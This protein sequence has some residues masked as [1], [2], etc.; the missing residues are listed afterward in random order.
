MALTQNYSKKVDFIPIESD[1][2]I[3]KL[4]N[5]SLTEEVIIKNAYTKITK[6]DGNKNR[7]KILV[8][9]YNNDKKENLLES[10]EYYFVPDISE[11]SENFIRQGYLYLK[12]L[13]EFAGA[14]DC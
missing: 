2:L 7:I 5:K 8:C 3:E 10:K 11:N 14:E 12:T 1:Y 13:N 6:I 4:K 9:T